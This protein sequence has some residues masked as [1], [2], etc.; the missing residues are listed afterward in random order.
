MFYVVLKKKMTNK[1]NF[2]KYKFKQN[3]LCGWKRN[4]IKRLEIF[5]H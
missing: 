5:Y 1:E 3:L 4:K 2:G